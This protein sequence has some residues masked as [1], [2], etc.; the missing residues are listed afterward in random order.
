MI[1]APSVLSVDYSH[2]SEQMK[3]LNESDAQWIHYD[4]M[5]G[6]FVPNLTFGPDILKGFRKLSDRFL[7]VHLMITDPI[8]YS[9][10]F[11]DAGAD[12]ITFHEEALLD[13]EKIRSLAKHLRL[14]GI[15][16]GLSIKPKTDLDKLKPYLEDF[17]LFLIMSV[18][19]GF[20]GQ[21]FMPDS[22]ERVRTLRSWLDEL[23]LNTHIEVDGGINAE[24]G[25]LIKEAGADV[26]VAGSYV[27]K[28]NIKEAVASLE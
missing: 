28:N 24:T 18:E 17:D 22:I 8:Y 13:E 14:R 2:L 12:G 19:P 23:H 15:Q 16:A 7:D 3:E 27:F 5:D 1:I 4:V 20:G 21:K 11:I 9:D 10:I 26:L 25:K 6:H